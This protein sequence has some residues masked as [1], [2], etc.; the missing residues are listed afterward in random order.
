MELLIWP[1]KSR[2]ARTYIQQLCEDT[3]CSPEDLLEVMNDREEWRERETGI[4]V[5]AARHDNDHEVSTTYRTKIIDCVNQSIY[6]SHLSIYLIS[7]F[8]SI[9]L[10]IYL[11]SFFLSFFL[12]IY[13]FLPIYLSS[14]E[15]LPEAMND[16]EEWRERVRYIH[17]GGVRWWW[18][19]MIL[20][21]LF[22]AK[23]R[24]VN[25]FIITF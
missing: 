19:M 22:N 18:W 25:I 21:R 7:F 23:F 4:S 9:Y 15:N 1:N 13:L 16:R 8:P 6:L 2:T 20:C 12:S 3:G 17:A 24:L 5:L 10:C 11:I 14:P